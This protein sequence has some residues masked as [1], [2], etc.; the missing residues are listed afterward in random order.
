[1][2]FLESTVGLQ[3]LDQNMHK[4]IIGANLDH[5]CPVSVRMASFECSYKSSEFDFSV[6]TLN[7]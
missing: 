1:M 4:S 2:S 7:D 6:D 5:D 3:H